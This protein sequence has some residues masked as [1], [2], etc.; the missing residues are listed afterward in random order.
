MSDLLAEVKERYADRYII[1]DSPPPQL[2]S[3]T[4]AISRQV[5]GILLV[6]NYGKTPRNDISDL[7]EMVGKE[8]I[9]GTVFNRIDMPLSSYFTYKRYGKYGGKYKYHS[10]YHK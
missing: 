9:L 10:K 6:V 4:M 3:E 7:I 8:K 5:D 2:T 1:I